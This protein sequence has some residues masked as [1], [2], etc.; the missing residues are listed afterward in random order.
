MPREKIYM[1]KIDEN[2]VH[3]YEKSGLTLTVL[4]TDR[5]KKDCVPDRIYG[6]REFDK[7][8]LVDITETIDS[9]TTLVLIGGRNVSGIVEDLRKAVGRSDEKSIRRHSK[10]LDDAVRSLR[11]ESKALTV[12]LEM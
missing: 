11:G 5:L 9:Q 3:L 10:R 4:N 2:T 1:M 7:N 6:T 8:C 12:M